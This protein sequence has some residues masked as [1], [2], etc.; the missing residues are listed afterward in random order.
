MLILTYFCYFFYDLD[1]RLEEL[2]FII[3][4]TIYIT[5]IKPNFANFKEQIPNMSVIPYIDR[6]NFKIIS[7]YQGLQLPYDM[8]PN[9][10]E[11]KSNGK[12]YKLSKRSEG[13]N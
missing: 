8:T 6:N 3:G 11:V 2:P 5:Y 12:Q 4:K 9:D 10:L 1:K 7:L 13:N